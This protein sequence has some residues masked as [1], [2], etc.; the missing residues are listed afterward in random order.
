M[1]KASKR[2]LAY[3]SEYQKSPEEVRK[4]VARNKARRAA[5]R[6]GEAHVGDGTEVNHK[7]PLS[8]GGSTAKSNTEV[9]P[10][11]KNRAHGMT[12]PGKPAKRRK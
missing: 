7:R 5:I 1:A 12:A 10:R 4:R 2:K 11:S 9:V 6:A 8:R 3:M